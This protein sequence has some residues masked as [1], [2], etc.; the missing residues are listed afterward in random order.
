M[1]RETLLAS[2]MLP[3]I[4]D[5]NNLIAGKLTHSSRPLF[6]SEITDNI[7]V[8]EMAATLPPQLYSVVF[9]TGK[10]QTIEIIATRP[11]QL[12][13]NIQ[14]IE[15][16]V[17]LPPQLLWVVSITEDIQKKKEYQPL[18]LHSCLQV[19]SRCTLVIRLPVG[20]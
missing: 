17:I 9:T 7:Q 4:N 10:I 5:I 6:N 16:V 20:V 14:G 12:P 18:Y 8:T 1:H 15:T 13:D 3:S 19:A 11:L 2:K